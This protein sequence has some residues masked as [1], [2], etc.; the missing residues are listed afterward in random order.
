MPAVEDT[1]LGPIRLGPQPNPSGTAPDP[2]GRRAPPLRGTDGYIEMPFGI[3]A[4][5][6]SVALFGGVVRSRR[7]VRPVPPQARVLVRA[8]DL[9]DAA[10]SSVR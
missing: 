9:P 8:S 10:A 4:A 5:P 6:L 3:N 1:S 2:R 7:T